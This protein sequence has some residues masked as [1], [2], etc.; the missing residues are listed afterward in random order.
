MFRNFLKKAFQKCLSCVIFA[1][2]IFAPFLRPLH[3]AQAEAPIPNPVLVGTFTGKVCPSNVYSHPTTNPVTQG[4]KIIFGASDETG[5]ALWTSDGSL[6]G[7]YPYYPFPSGTCIDDDF[8]AY[9]HGKVIFSISTGD[10]ARQVYANDGSANGTVFLQEIP[11]DEMKAYQDLVY[12][13]SWGTS[14]PLSSAR[15]WRTDG[16][17]DGTF[18]LAE[19]G[20]YVYDTSF[21]LPFIFAYLSPGDNPIIWHTDGTVAGTVQVNKDGQ[22][23]S[24]QRISEEKS[25]LDVLN[26][27]DL[28]IWISDNAYTHLVKLTSFPGQTGFHGGFVGNANGLAFFVLKGP[29]DYYGDYFETLWQTDGTLAGTEQVDADFEY[30]GYLGELRGIGVN[31]NTLYFRLWDGA[32]IKLYCTSGKEGGVIYLTGMEQAVKSFVHFQDKLYYLNTDG[33]R[34]TIFA[35]DGQTAGPIGFPAT[36]FYDTAELTATNFGFM[37]FEAFL[38]NETSDWQI[39]YTDGTEANTQILFTPDHNSDSWY[40]DVYGEVIDFPIL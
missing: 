9:T 18:Q 1:S 31:N 8:I 17:P 19:L 16:T 40:P 29:T 7:T 37:T 3:P 20:G 39:F 4:N 35:V 33:G 24:I 38:V 27:D 11:Y 26:G 23:F 12:F 32:D 14:I 22:P 13:I 21:G 5:V 6:D 10:G 28:E 36:R 34:E 30:S 25:I 2:F 15:I